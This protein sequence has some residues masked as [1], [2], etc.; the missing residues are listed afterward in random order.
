[1][2]NVWNNVIILFN[3]FT[4]LKDS[5]NCVAAAYCIYLVQPF[6]PLV[7]LIISVTYG[8]LESSMRNDLQL[9]LVIK[10]LT[11]V[12]M[13]HYTELMD[14]CHPFRVF[15]MKMVYYNYPAV[16]GMMLQLFRAIIVP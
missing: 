15:F 8:Y 14:T 9:A 7:G 2:N 4:V 13:S 16:M 1:M 11:I 6:S 5:T 12:V 3:F 10:L